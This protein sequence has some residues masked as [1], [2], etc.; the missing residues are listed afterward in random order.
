MVK[1]DIIVEIS[2]DEDD[3]TCY[4]CPLRDS[5]NEGCCVAFGLKSLIKGQRCEECKKSEEHV[6]GEFR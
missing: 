2:Y 1:S 3:G 5:E 4:D 6:L